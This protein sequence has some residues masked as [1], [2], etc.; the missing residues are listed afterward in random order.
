MEDTKCFLLSAKD[1]EAR[2]LGCCPE[3]EIYNSKFTPK[4]GKWALGFCG[5]LY[6]KDNP[7]GSDES[8]HELQRVTSLDLSNRCIQNLISKVRI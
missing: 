5:G 7:G 1:L 4:Y 6:E 8:D 3:L 2:I